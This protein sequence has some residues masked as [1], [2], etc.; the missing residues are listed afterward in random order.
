MNE[1]TQTNLD[2]FRA[3]VAHAGK[4][5]HDMQREDDSAER[6]D[7]YT[8]TLVETVIDH[9]AAFLDDLMHELIVDVLT[10]TVTDFLDDTAEST[11]TA[12]AAAGR[13]VFEAA[14]SQ[15]DS[16]GV[17]HILVRDRILD[18][19]VRIAHQAHHDAERLALA[20]EVVE[21]RIRDGR[22]IRLDHGGVIEASRF[23]PAVHNRAI[24]DD[25]VQAVNDAM[26]GGETA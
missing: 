7:A 5:L 11:Y 13:I 6:A 9:A 1:Q 26:T 10:D 3:D 8:C 25:L 20:T 19:A 16:A 14:R 18:E 15:Q 21:E 23:D 17:L 22:L 24:P 4:L 2:R 12:A